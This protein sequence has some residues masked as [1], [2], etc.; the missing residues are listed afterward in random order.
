VLSDKLWKTTFAEDPAIVG[1]IISLNG[2]LFTVIGIAPERFNYPD[3]VEAWRPLIWADWMI[4]PGNRGAHWL[5]G[6]GRVKPGVPVA[7]AKQ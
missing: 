4:D 5:A 6:I 3:R 2:N 7:T 1:K